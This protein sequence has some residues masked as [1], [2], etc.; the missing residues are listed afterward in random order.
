[1]GEPKFGEPLTWEGNVFDRNGR[2][3]EVE[4]PFEYENLMARMVASVNALAGVPHP[5]RV[6]ELLEAMDRA[7]VA[8]TRTARHYAL[9]DAQ[10]AYRRVMEEAPNEQD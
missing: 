4:A 5:E 9:A 1:M 2:D 3:M 7:Q 10:S 8:T 6:G